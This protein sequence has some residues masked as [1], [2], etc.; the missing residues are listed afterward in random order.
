MLFDFCL[1]YP[2]NNLTCRLICGQRPGRERPGKVFWVVK[3]WL[4]LVC[5]LLHPTLA[6]CIVLPQRRLIKWSAPDRWHSDNISPPYPGLLLSAGPKF[7]ERGEFFQQ[8]SPELATKRLCQSFLFDQTTTPLRSSPARQFIVMSLGHPVPEER[9]L[10]SCVRVII[11]DWPHQ[12]EQETQISKDMQLA[13]RKLP[14]HCVYSA[15]YGS[16]YELSLFTLV[17]SLGL[18][19]QKAIILIKEERVWGRRRERGGGGE[20]GHRCIGSGLVMMPQIPSVVQ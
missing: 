4:S 16:R 12:E 19:N 14:R 7:L 3:E 13:A 1:P 2:P 18:E 8:F 20:G 6:Q 10:C 15:L 9:V 5:A 11:K 17:L